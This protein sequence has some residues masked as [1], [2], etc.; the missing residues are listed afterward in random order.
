MELL[1][2]GVILRNVISTMK[3]TWTVTQDRAPSV[4]RK[5]LLTQDSV[6]NAASL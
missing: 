2:K 3:E 5:H 6:T 4:K 1:K